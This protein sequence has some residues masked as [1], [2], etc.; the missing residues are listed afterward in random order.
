MHAE[1]FR[2]CV[3]PLAATI[4]LNMRRQSKQKR[5]HLGKQGLAA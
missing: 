1:F 5:V 3:M 4:Q 2:P